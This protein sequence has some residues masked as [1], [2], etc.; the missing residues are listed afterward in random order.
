MA[1]VTFEGSVGELRECLKWYED[2]A[3][4]KAEV[5][6]R[7]RFPAPNAPVFGSSASARENDAERKVLEAAKVW[8]HSFALSGLRDNENAATALRQA[9]NEL[10]LGR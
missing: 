5:A 9:V 7:Q 8:H 2:E 1:K 3:L 4:V 6:G 10:E